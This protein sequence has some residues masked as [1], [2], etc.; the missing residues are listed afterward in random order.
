MSTPSNFVAGKN[1]HGNIGLNLLHLFCKLCPDCP[2]QH[3]VGYDRANRRV[4]KDF[5]GISRHRNSNHVV[6]V[7]LQESLS[8]TQIQLVILDAEDERL[9]SHNKA[10]FSQKIL[11][12]CRQKYPGEASML[13]HV[14]SG[15]NTVNTVRYSTNVSHLSCVAPFG[16][17]GI[18]VSVLRR[19]TIAEGGPPYVRRVGT[20]MSWVN[21]SHA[22]RT[23]H[24]SSRA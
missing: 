18:W 16:D 11:V 2:L 13:S 1:N 15:V 17:R 5:Q 12:W 20:T 4:L 3:V 7:L 9:G 6:T 21:S 19:P 23:K 14:A 10:R 24:L 8:Q 22:A